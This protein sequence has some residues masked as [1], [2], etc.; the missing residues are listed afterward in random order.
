MLKGQKIT[1]RPFNKNDMQKTL[2][3]RNDL[4]ISDLVMSHPFPV[5][6]DAEKS[7]FEQNLTDKSN[8]S[9]YF[10]IDENQSG[11]LVGY[12]VIN[13]INWISRVCE[14]GILIGESEMRGKGLGEDVLRIIFEY[15][16][17]ILNL[18]KII[19]MVTSSNLPAIKLYERMGFN[20]EGILKEHTHVRGEYVDVLV[21]SK[22]NS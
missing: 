6:E 13:N 18:R 8:R 4:E 3:W 7:W 19:L 22:F 11:I 17:E 5:S 2:K 20:S 10:A 15:T 1:L 21:M 14:F 16:F 9:I 12:T